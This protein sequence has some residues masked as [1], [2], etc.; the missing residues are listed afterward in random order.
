MTGVADREYGEKAAAFVVLRP[1]AELTLDDVREH[2]ERLGVARQKTPE[3][4]VVKDAMP[5]TGSGKI[6]KRQLR[7]ELEA[8]IH[9]CEAGP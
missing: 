9:A 8:E 5:R 7:E 2:F 1:G 3:Y 4:L 6:A